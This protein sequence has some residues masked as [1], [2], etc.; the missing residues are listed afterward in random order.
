MLAP[1]A[2]IVPGM[3]V[4]NCGGRC[5]LRAH[6]RDGKIQRIDSASGPES[7][8]A[9]ALRACL[10]CRSY[11]NILGHPDR[12]RQPL[13]RTGPRGEGRFK[14]VGWDEAL[15]VIAAAL[16]ASRDRHGP[17]SRLVLYGWGDNGSMCG[18][19][20][21]RRLLN[22]H[23]GQ[24]EYYNNYSNP[25][26][27]HATRLCYGT[28]LSGN[29]RSDLVHARLILL[30]GHNPAETVFDTNTMYF[31]R[32]AR[33]RG[34][35]V[36]VID[37]RLTDTA[38]AL[39]DEWIPIRPTTDC[40]LMDAL[41]FVLLS[42]HLQDQAF[43]DRCCVGF[44]DQHL[45]EGA[46]PGH[47]YQGYLQGKLD[48]VAKT[49]AWAAPICGVPAD[50]IDRLA[51]ALGVTKPA[52]ILCGYGPQRHA[53]GEQFAR[54]AIALAAMTGNVGIPGGWASGKGGYA[55]TPQI[56]IPALDNPVPER[57]P[58]FLW[59]DAVTRGTEMTQ[60]DGVRGADRLS[61]NVRVLLQI[62]GNS[63]INQ[64]ADINRTREIVADES[65]VDFVLVS[66]LF[67]TPSA[68]FADIVLPSTAC[69]EREDILV[70]WD[71]GDYVGFANKAVDPPDGCRDDYD[72]I[73]ELARRLGVDQRFTEGRS[74]PQWLRS[75]LDAQ[76]VRFPSLPDFESLEADG[77]AKLPWPAPHIAFADSAA[78]PAQHPFPTPS[79]RIELFSSQ[80]AAMQRPDDLP[81]TPRY[82]P[83]WEGPAD[84][85][86]ARFPLQLIGWHSRARVHSIFHNDPWMQQ[87][88][89]LELWL[90]PQDAATR[91]IRE[92]DRVRVLNDRG[93]TLIA[94]HVTP[95]IMPGVVGMMH[96][97]W[98]QPGDDGVDRG[99]CINVLTSQRTTPLAFGNAQHT[100]LVEVRREPRDTP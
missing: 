27:T 93:A 21:M 28:E 52:A 18:A 60:A 65:L 7:A 74:R 82:L 68:K 55:R 50:T 90:N 9:P 39:A 97:A 43:L 24:A 4:H 25:A 57:F 75:L 56:E 8:D 2:R 96:G 38:V 81:A 36:V 16:T 80:L 62:A 14:P 69:W 1:A 26:A 32:Q 64:H 85:L 17:A 46:A 59:T 12:L 41:A 88:A 73:G 86:R 87:A 23:A 45:P 31:L 3:G 15:D 89:P 72:W 61:C 54:G 99:G 94:A 19:R 44:D 84:P 51:R 98:Y 92:G 49:P 34:A 48:G 10:R 66:D 40:A 6:V 71:A 95:R 30:W 100:I 91:G 5:V 78:D 53:F 63:L 47:S 29:S 20:L 35:R 83:A 22:C 77:I 58:V 76:R 67:M 11:R 70:P 33:D 79:G 42:E 37:P 13:R